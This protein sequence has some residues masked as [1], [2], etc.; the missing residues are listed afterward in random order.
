MPKPV[1]ARMRCDS[2]V[3]AA[4]VAGGMMMGGCS[5]F[6]GLWD[7][8]D[9]DNVVLQGD[10]VSVMTSEQSITVDPEASKEAIIVPAAFTNAEWSQPGGTA[11]N[12]FQ[13]V[14]LG[15]TLTR[16]WSANAGSGSSSHGRLTASPIVFGN[17]IFT[18]DT[19]ATVHA[20]EA[21][22]GKRLWSVALTPEEEESDEGYGGGLAAEGGRLFVSIGFGHVAALDPATGKQVWRKPLG[23]PIRS[24]PTAAGGRVYVTTMNNEVY[25]LS[26]ADGDVTWKYQG[27]TETAALLTST[28]PAVSKGKVI[29]PHTSGEIIAFETGTGNPLWTDSLTRA[30]GLS[31]LANINAIAGRPVIDRDTV[32]AISHSGLMAAFD[33][34][35]GDRRWTQDIAGTQ[36]PWVAGS[37]VFLVSERGEL[38]ALSGKT[39]GAKWVQKLGSDA[40][41]SGPVLA[42]GRLILVSSKG[43]VR[44]ISPQNGRTIDAINL[45]EPMMISPV[46][47]GNTIYF[48]TDGGD[49]VAMR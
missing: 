34:N 41:W 36:T 6:S 9:G 40:Q 17:R 11:S 2:A 35:S 18:L 19:K 25:A 15:G 12:A 5:S 47:A 29:V 3:V 43:T 13:H 20:I 42:G 28:S 23:V 16:L 45:G 4:I 49:L 44:S 24:A 21:A 32:F 37:Y 39:G 1:H 22:S 8:G 46:V 26:Q 31:S 10:R 27:I 14:A 7:G 33:L 30:G 38:T 48:Y